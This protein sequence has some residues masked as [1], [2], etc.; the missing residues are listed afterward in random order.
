MVGR[1]LKGG[2]EGDPTEC[3]VGGAGNGMAS[4]TRRP[5]VSSSSVYNILL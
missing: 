2:C 3:C 4:R 5:N 1:T